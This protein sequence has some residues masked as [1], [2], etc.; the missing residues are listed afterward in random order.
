M[1]VTVDRSQPTYATSSLNTSRRG[2]LPPSD[3]ASES[4]R[5]E[6]SVSRPATIDD[7]VGALIDVRRAIS[8]LETGACA[9]IASN[10][11]VRFSSRS[12]DGVPI[13]SK[14]V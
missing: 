11:I 10:T 9:R 5:R 3:D 1:R 6:P 13:F 8:A 7:T 4:S 14:L 12:V 2:G